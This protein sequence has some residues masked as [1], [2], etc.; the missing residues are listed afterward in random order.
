MGNF[1]LSDGEWKMMNV[2]WNTESRT[3]GQITKALEPET[4]WSRPTAYVML[5]RLISKGIVRLDDSTRIQSYHPLIE[6]NDIIPEVTESILNRVFDGSVSLMVSA[7]T[8]RRKL[9]EKEIRKIR[10]ILDEAEKGRDSK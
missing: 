7:L 4:G 10:K 3:L 1:Q 8:E 6:R 2:L 5:K 9:S